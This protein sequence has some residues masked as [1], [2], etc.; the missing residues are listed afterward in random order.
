MGA[1][2]TRNL[3]PLADADLLRH[4][5][6]Q[7]QEAVDLTMGGDT[8]PFERFPEVAPLLKRSRIAG[9]F[10]TAPELLNV[11]EAMVVSRVMR[12]FLR[13]REGAVV[14]LQRL[15][16]RLVDDRLLEKHITD[17]ID[18]TGL[19]RD[20]ASR[21]L[22]SIRREIHTLEA[23]LRSRLERILKKFGEEELLQDEFIT[24]RDGRFVL[25]LQ[26]QN[27]RAVDGIIHG[28]SQSGQTVFLEPAE[29]YELN[30]ELSLLRGRE[31]REI[32]NILT[33]L[34]AEIGSVS[35]DLEAAADVLVEIDTILARAR[36]AAEYGGLKPTIIDEDDI[37]LTNVRHPILLHQARENRKPETGNH[38]GQ[39]AHEAVIPLSV[40]IGGNARG[41]LISGPN[42]G[43][44]TVAMKTIGLSLSMAFCGVFPIG[45]CQSPLRRIYTS[46]GDHQSIDANLST[47]SSQIIRLRDVMAEVDREALVLIDE[48]CA[49]TDPA[50]GGALAAGILD[51]LLERGSCFVVTTHQ[52][53][54]KQYALTRDLITNA[55]LAFD[56]ERMVPTFRFLYG[57]PGNSYAFDLARNVGLPDVVLTRGRSYLGERHDELEESIS[58]MQRFREEAERMK[59][60]AAEDRAAAQKAR[61]DYEERLAQIKAKRTT[62]LEEARTQAAEILSKANALVENTIREIREQ[63]KNAAEIKRE[64]ESAKQA[65]TTSSRAT[66]EQNAEPVDTWKV[67]SVARIEGTATSGTILTI[68]DK[69]HAVLDV[70]G[71][72][73]R[74]ALDKL[75]HVDAKKARKEERQQRSSPVVAPH[76]NHERVEARQP[77]RSEGPAMSLDL[78]GMRA[79]EAL[80]SLEVFI[81]NAIIRNLPFVSI[82]HGKG[83]GALREVTH[84][85]LERQ[86]N[87]RCFRLGTI[88]EGGDGVTIVEL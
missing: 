73:M 20:N 5:L 12:R 8:V 15:S 85:F 16:E 54:L 57:V 34:T 50:E 87:L 67:G 68:D 61:V 24:Q 40:R 52:S 53:S 35:Y 10:L 58:A 72:K 41:I 48:I 82:I 36:Y 59:F 9:N 27:K 31:Q 47:F 37:E 74:V 83:T 42:A 26:V 60:A 44:K 80:R 4:K 51:S 62:S 43:G 64:F 79:D 70:N 25:P 71:M 84:Q 56:E 49:G 65:L 66:P 21:E 39:V 11:L 14:S 88:P 32:I 75:E 7:V 78:R 55:S 33:T 17:A 23:R 46:I 28:M 3:S 45:A 38:G 29:T 6:D 69:G 22:L 77:D 81:D 76:Q 1:E 2:A 13:E 18:D 86:G 63:Q 19:V 30:N